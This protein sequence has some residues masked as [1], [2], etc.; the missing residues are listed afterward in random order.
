[1][2]RHASTLIA[3]AFLLVA[4]A[5]APAA[6]PGSLKRTALPGG[7]ILE[8]NGQREHLSVEVVGAGGAPSLVLTSVTDEAF[9]KLDAAATLVDGA[10]AVVRRQGL[11]GLR[12]VKASLARNGRSAAVL[13]ASFSD[14]DA[15]PT[16]V[17]FDADG[18][19]WKKAA[20]KGDVGVLAGGKWVAI[21]RRSGADAG[22]RFFRPGGEPLA[23]AEPIK[24]PL[25]RVGDGGVAAASG[26]MLS[27]FDAK[28]VRRT[29]VPLGFTAGIP[30]AAADG[31]MIA[32]AE[33]DEKDEPGRTLVLF[34]RAG[35]SL[36]KIDHR[37]FTL[38]V[39]I[40]ADGSAFLVAPST[41][42]RKTALAEGEGG[43]L[44]I[45]A[46]DRTGAPRWRHDVEPRS[47]T[48]HVA[49][50]SIAAG[51]GRAVVALRVPDAS[52]PERLL[53]FD[54]AGKVIYRAEGV[55][56]GAWLDEKGESLFTAEPG[57][58][59]RLTVDALVKGTAFPSP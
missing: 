19:N 24:G 52:V 13:A 11:A 38:D 16:L 34:D 5:K 48:E 47:P 58:L 49:W 32:V 43:G 12:P 25:A 31:S 8:V 46:Y 22:A 26:G 2:R 57:A 29:H 45:S 44:S 28:L 23:P 42:G 1:M 39:A 14:P 59:S 18:G 17:A 51:G 55:L 7:W 27:I 53:V 54:A 15:A 4:A 33:V 36:G 35:K 30:F 3:A 10:G 9:K 40:A 50:M 56:R 37:A 6:V 20:P 21:F 41:V